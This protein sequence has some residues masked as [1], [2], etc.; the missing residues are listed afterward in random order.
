MP[1][2]PARPPPHSLPSC[3]PRCRPAWPST[4]AAAAPLT[5][6]SARH[7]PQAAAFDYWFHVRP[8]PVVPRVSDMGRVLPLRGYGSGNKDL[9]QDV[10]AWR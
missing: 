1:S 8:P 7:A 5:V 2:C 4:R 6:L 9:L 3:L 10:P